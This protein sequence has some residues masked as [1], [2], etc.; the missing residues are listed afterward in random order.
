MAVSGHVEGV[1]GHGENKR[2]SKAS[3]LR[4]FQVNPRCP[5]TGKLAGLMEEGMLWAET[6]LVRKNERSSRG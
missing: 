5:E 4:L 1:A 3:P 2:E 6:F